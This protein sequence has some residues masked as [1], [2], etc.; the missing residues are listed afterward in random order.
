[1]LVETVVAGVVHVA[2][3][4][5]DVVE[6]VADEAVAEDVDGASRC[7]NRHESVKAKESA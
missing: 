4:A 1:L 3:V 6:V 5:A 7:E 2:A